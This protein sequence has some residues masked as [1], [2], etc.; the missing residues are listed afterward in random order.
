MKLI[1]SQRR[2]YFFCPTVFPCLYGFLLVWIYIWFRNNLINFCRCL[3]LK[4]MSARFVAR[5]PKIENRFI[6][7]ST[8][9]FF[10]IKSKCQKKRM[11]ANSNFMKLSMFSDLGTGHHLPVF[12][13]PVQNCRRTRKSF[14]FD[15]LH[16]S[17]PYT[18]KLCKSLYHIIWACTAQYLYNE[19]SDIR[20]VQIK[21]TVPS[22][23]KFH[24]M[25]IATEVK[26]IWR[27]LTSVFLL[28]FCLFVYL[29]NCAPFQK[30]FEI[31]KFFEMGHN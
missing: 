29:R 27:P 25:G 14:K 8:S 23:P 22:R 19:S 15:K 13:V 2:F 26:K 30:N 11:F 4:L 5:P 31:L 16:D 3:Q 28:W 9:L 17:K 12:N 21:E 20:L 10:S 24:V 18:L 1:S 6:V 7:L